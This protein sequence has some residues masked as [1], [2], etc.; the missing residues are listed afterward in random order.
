MSDSALM[1]SNAQLQDTKAECI[2]EYNLPTNSK[3]L[4]ILCSLLRE[5]PVTLAETTLPVGG[6]SLHRK[7]GFAAA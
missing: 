2:T 7:D 3:F 5:V 6:K 4:L 1:H